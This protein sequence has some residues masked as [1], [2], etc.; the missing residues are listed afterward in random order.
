MA[1]VIH[2]TIPW[3]CIFSNQHVGKKKEKRP[4]ISSETDS[5]MRQGSTRTQCGFQR[6]GLQVRM[7]KKHVFLKIPANACFC[8]IQT[9][10][11]KLQ[12]VFRAF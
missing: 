12:N 3:L 7:R 6:H 10:K 2:P 1:L 9:T 8:R 4:F 5:K 11:T